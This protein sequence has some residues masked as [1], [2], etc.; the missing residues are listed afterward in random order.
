MLQALRV[1]AT[2]SNRYADWP[3]DGVM[4]DKHINNQ[5]MKKKFDRL[6]QRQF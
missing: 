5:D 3:G 4:L 2:A 6:C 1:Q